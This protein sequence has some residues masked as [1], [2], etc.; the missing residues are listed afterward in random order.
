MTRIAL[1]MS[2][3]LLFERAS[4]MVGIALG[5]ELILGASMRVYLLNIALYYAYT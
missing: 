2:C 4:L 5:R 3:I 1:D